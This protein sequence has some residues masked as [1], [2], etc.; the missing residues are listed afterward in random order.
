MPW[1]SAR[2]GPLS[3][4]L[5]TFWELI[6]VPLRDRAASRPPFPRRGGPGKR[7]DRSTNE[8]VGV[9]RA[10]AAGSCPRDG[11]RAEAARRPPARRAR[12]SEY[13]L[14]R[15]VEPGV[16]DR[17]QPVQPAGGRGLRASVPAAETGASRTARERRAA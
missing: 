13:V 1:M 16:P 14:G 4:R 12:V 17:L 9:P 5:S 6:E 7:P 2:A 15:H 8:E 3:G 10:R 11:L